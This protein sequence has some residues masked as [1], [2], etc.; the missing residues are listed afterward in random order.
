MRKGELIREN[1]LLKVYLRKTIKEF[2]NLH[3]LL[4]AIL[5]HMVADKEMNI[6][7]IEKKIADHLFIIDELMN[8]KWEDLNE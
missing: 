6:D 5:I 2:G 3:N 4:D 1:K 8:P 7:I